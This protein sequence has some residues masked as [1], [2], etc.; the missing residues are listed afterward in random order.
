MFT[1]ANRIVALSA[2]IG[3]LA[4][5]VLGALWV[6]SENTSLVTTEGS[7]L[8]GLVEVNG[9]QNIVHL[10]SGCVLLASGIAGLSAARIAN[11]AVGILFLALGLIALFTIGSAANLLAVNGWGNVIHF[12]CAATLLGAGLG[13]DRVPIPE[14]LS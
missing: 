10:A 1:T 6:A 8:F 12:A 14:S 9:L 7:F 11:V 2:G 3:L 4:L 5:G 13:G